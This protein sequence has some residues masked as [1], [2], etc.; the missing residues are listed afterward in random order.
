MKTP[1]LK[2][3]S[4][5]EIVVYPD[6]CKGNYLFIEGK[7]QNEFKS[8][9]IILKKYDEIKLRNISFAK[10]DGDLPSRLVTAFRINNKYDIIPAECSLGVVNSNRPKKHFSWMLVSSKFNTQISWV[11]YSEIYGGCPES[12]DLVFKL[13]LDNAKHPLEM[14]YKYSDFK[15]QNL[16]LDN[17]FP[18]NLTLSKSFGYLTI[19]SSY[20][21]LMFFSSLEKKH[22]IT[23]EHAF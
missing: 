20:G 7:N 8:G 19:W 14:K 6:S 12:T 22:S 3:K 17:I 1:Y 11:D 2:N 5:N 16:T 4:S 10:K 21:G 9:N 23:L 13:Y 15:E 18:K